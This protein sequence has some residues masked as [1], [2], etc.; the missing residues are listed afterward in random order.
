MKFE[1][2]RLTEPVVRAVLAEGYTRPT[3][4]QA[5]AIPHVMQGRDVLGCA[6]TGTGKTAAFALPIL[7]RLSHGRPRTP[8][9]RPIRALILAPTR[10]LAAQIGDSFHAYGRHTP[11]R[12]AVIFGGVSQHPQTRALRE[13]VDILVAT[14]GRLLDLMEQG[15]VDLRAVESLVLDEADRMLDMGFIRDIRK[16]VAQVPARRQTLLFSATM[17]ADIRALADTILHEPVFVQAAAVSSTAETIQQAVYFVE[18]RQKPAMLAHLLRTSAIKRALVF[19]RTKHGADVVARH[20]SRAG[21]RAEAIHGNKSQNARVRAITQFKSDRPPVLVA[22]DIAARGLDIDEIS[23]V[24]NY[25]LP[26]V[27]ET[28][29]HRI[30]RTGRAGASG[31]AMS[32]CDS[33]ERPFLRDIER[34]IARTIHV[35]RPDGDLAL[36]PAPRPEAAENP[37]CQRQDSTSPR[38]PGVGYRLR[39]RPRSRRLAVR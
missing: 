36:P 16:I 37:P 23:H 10:E 15:F 7:H 26:N 8:H 3:P 14:P 39:G 21:I 24:I 31:R 4:I 32:F 1:E 9:G 17:P 38:Q 22:T 34:L 13:G 18:K 29:V 11:L 5:K 30:G 28:Y 25:D 35:I 19:T 33:S 27:P 20:L 6:Q 2:F 12:S